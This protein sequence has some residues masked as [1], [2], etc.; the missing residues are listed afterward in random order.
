VI[1]ANPELLERDLIKNHSIAVG[2]IDALWH[3]GVDAE[4]ARLAAHAG[5]QLFI[6]AYAHWLEAAAKAELARMCESVMPLLTSIVPA[7]VQPPS[8]RQE[9]ARVPA[10]QTDPSPRRGRVPQDPGVAVESKV[11]VPRVSKV[12]SRHSSQKD[13]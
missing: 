8:S 13:G 3:R 12:G 7:N 9:N 2:F 6:T 4:I 10:S 1:A 11:T 5:I